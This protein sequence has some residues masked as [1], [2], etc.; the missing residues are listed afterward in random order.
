MFDDKDIDLASIS[1]CNHWHALSVNAIPLRTGRP[2]SAE[3]A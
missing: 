1:T 3:N 2:D